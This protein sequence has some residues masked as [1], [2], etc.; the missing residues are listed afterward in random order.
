MKKIIDLYLYKEYRL[1]KEFKDIVAIEKNLEYIFLLDGI[2]TV[3][4][5]TRFVRETEEYKFELNIKAKTGLYLLKSQNM[6]FDIEVE[7]IMYK[8]DN[9]NIILEYK[10][11]SDEENFKI[12]LLIKDD[13]NE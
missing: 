7:K 13:N 11:S 12:E 10:I 6:N 4:G 2:K 9:N 1:D 5:P 8:K 3:V